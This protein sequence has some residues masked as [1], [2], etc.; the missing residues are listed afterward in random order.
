MRLA[1]PILTL[2]AFCWLA[3]ESYRDPVYD[4]AGLTRLIASTQS[5]KLDKQEQYELAVYL[6]GEK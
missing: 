5:H 3:Y 4:T 2:I 6:W 1:I